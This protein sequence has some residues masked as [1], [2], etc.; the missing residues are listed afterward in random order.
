MN[1]QYAV[2]LEKAYQTPEL[3]GKIWHWIENPLAGY[4]G[5]AM[6]KAPMLRP[7]V[8]TQKQLQSISTPAILDAMVMAQ[9]VAAFAPQTSKETGTQMSLDAAF[10]NESK[11]WYQSEHKRIE[12][13]LK[14]Y[15]GEI[16]VDYPTLVKSKSDDLEY[17]TKNAL[18]E[19]LSILGGDAIAKH[20]IEGVSKTGRWFWGDT[21]WWDI[22]NNCLWQYPEVSMG[23]DPE[24]V[25]QYELV[26][27]NAKK[28]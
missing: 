7:F 10:P 25:K 19:I 27:A 1:T 14:A 3:E 16:E 18:I 22:S 2:L 20:H 9:G 15:F 17:D 26:V 28:K 4:G 24:L 6:E 13:E 11:A 12:S 5:N 21:E 8:P 23:I